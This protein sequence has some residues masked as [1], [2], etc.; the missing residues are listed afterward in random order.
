MGPENKEREGFQL[1]AEICSLLNE[2]HRTPDLLLEY[3]LDS[4]MSLLC[5][6]FISLLL[7]NPS[8]DI[9]QKEFSRGIPPVLS[10][11]ELFGSQSQVLKYFKKKKD[12]IDTESGLL[13]VPFIANGT[14]EGML[15]LLS[16][17]SSLILEEKDL[18]WLKRFSDLA[19]LCVHRFQML[20]RPETENRAGDSLV[21]KSALMQGLADSSARMASVSSSVLITGESGTGKEVLA[22][23]IHSLSSRRN[24]P[25]VSVNCAAIPSELIESELFGYVKG[26]FTGA[27]KDYRGRF[28]Q[29][30]GGTLFLDE[31]G[32]LSLEAQA[33]ILRV[34]QEQQVEKL[35]S[36]ERKLVDIRYIAAT[37]R[38]LEEEVRAGRFRKDLYFRLH[39][40]PLRIPPL[41][42]RPE[43]IP[44]LADYFL[45]KYQ[46]KSNSGER[47]LSSEAIES[48]ISYHWPGNVREL[49]NTMER[50]I[51]M[52]PQKVI[53]SSDLSLSSRIDKNSDKYKDKTLKDAVTAFKR[54]YVEQV[55]KYHRGNQTKA[56]ADLGIQRT[57]LSRLLKELDINR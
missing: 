32:E 27:D 7:H 42:D 43:D 35:G 19:G 38:N 53:Q 56:A 20:H 15:L 51:I 11:E 52:S 50:A 9:L 26:A 30:D 16:D 29:A 18:L 36:T 47:T 23:R 17:P 3:I 8:S 1:F 6:D 14:L 22:R 45:K 21:F 57:Y 13:A 24:A 44:V 34:I 2:N 28:E 55:L 41:R 39:V 31:I 33:K 25:L 48:L 5:G 10:E 37:N 4:A 49:E 12:F 40:L 46:H 54:N